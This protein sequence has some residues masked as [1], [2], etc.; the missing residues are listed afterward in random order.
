MGNPVLDRMFRDHLRKAISLEHTP[1]TTPSLVEIKKRIE[2]V[3]SPQQALLRMKELSKK[4]GTLAF[5]YETTGLKPDDKRHRI[6]SV[7]FCLNGEDTWACDVTDALL[8]AL[9]SVLENPSLKKVMHNSKFE[10]RWSHA[11]V[12]KKMKGFHWC[13][14]T[15][16]HILDNRRGITGL[17]FQSYVN[18]GIADYEVGSKAYIKGNKEGFNL[19]AEMPVRE[20]LM[21][22]SLD[23][24]LTHM[25]YEKQ[26]QQ[27]GC[28]ET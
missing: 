23:S 16:A 1:I 8:P 27:M 13:T 5:D 21:Y 14:Q 25:L 19:M 22:C 2:L 3:L 18:F 9:A 15:N 24:H 11:K 20:R 6:L 28:F 4:Q 17:K 7:S 12:T 26:R 10:I